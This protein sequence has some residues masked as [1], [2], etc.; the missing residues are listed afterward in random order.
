MKHEIRDWMK[1]PSGFGYGGFG[2]GFGYGFGN[3]GSDADEFRRILAMPLNDL[4]V[5]IHDAELVDA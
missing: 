1:K 4:D 2:G 5:L 3:R